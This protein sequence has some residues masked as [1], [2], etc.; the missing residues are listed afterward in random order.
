MDGPR[1]YYAKWTKSYRKIK[2][3][4]DF[5]YIWNLKKKREINKNNKNI[6]RFLDTENKQVFARGESLGKRRK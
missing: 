5:N 2:K 1:W 3:P 6:N 4:Y